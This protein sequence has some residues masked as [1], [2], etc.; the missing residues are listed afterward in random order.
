MLRIDL[1]GSCIGVTCAADQ[2]CA[3]GGCRAIDVAPAELT[4]WTGTPPALDPDASTPPVDGGPLD[5]SS[6][7]RQRCRY[8]RGL[9]RGH[10]RGLRRRHRCGLRRRHRRG[11]RRGLRCGLRRRHRRGLRRRH[12]RELRC[13]LRRRHRCGSAR[14]RR[15]SVRADE[16]DLQRPRRRLQWDDRRWG[17]HELRRDELRQLRTP[18]QLPELGG[19]RLLGG[20]LHVDGRLQSGLRQLQ[21]YSTATAARPT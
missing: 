14:P 11:L 8:G 9:R 13:G 19:R 4:E 12:R 1:L 3:A 7:R 6:D 20:P 21:R 15:R 2:T 17:R 18:V 5:A 10:R 16:R